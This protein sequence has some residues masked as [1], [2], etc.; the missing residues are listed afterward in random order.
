[1]SSNPYVSPREQNESSS[2]VGN[3]RREVWRLGFVFGTMYFIQGITDPSEGLVAQPLMH[4]LKTWGRDSAQIGQLVALLSLPWSFK[5]VFGLITDFVPLAGYRRKGYLF[6]TAVVSVVGFLWISLGHFQSGDEMFLVLCLLAPTT[7]VAF[8]DVVT[9][10]LMIERSQPLGA[11]GQMQSIQWAAIYGAT[12]V[13]GTL[14]G[15]LSQRNLHTWAFFICGICSLP[16]L[17][18]SYGVREPAPPKSS[19]GFRVAVR[20]LARAV[21]SRRILGIAAFLFLWSFN[22]FST[23][24]LYKYMTVT[25]GFS[26]QFRGNM[27]SVQA[28]A[29]ITA[30]ATYGLYCRKVSMRWLVHLSILLGVL[31]TL[32]YGLMRGEWSAIFVSSVVGFTYMTATLIQLD[33]AAQVCPPR[34]AG[35]LFALLM[36]LSNLAVSLST[37]LGGDWYERGILRWGSVTSFNVLVGIGALFTA[38]CWFIMPRTDPRT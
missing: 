15:W 17:A 28:V 35:T 29:S 23:V 6:L 33:L 14:G 37:W 8:G 38:A 3:D 10:A 18:I 31:C 11:T 9:D 7:A 24:V 22:P 13:T 1:M 26:E 27:V 19:L 30:C 20:E 12:I 34:V 21:L 36:G 25:L 5:V 32:T 4:L 2:S 16:I